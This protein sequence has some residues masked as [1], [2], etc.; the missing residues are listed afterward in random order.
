[1]RRDLEAGGKWVCTC[2]PCHEIRSLIG[3]EKMLDVWPLVRE[4]RETEDRL[5]ELADGP[6]RHKLQQRYVKLS[7]KLADM[8]AKPA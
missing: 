1:M 8:M 6:E 2:D 7:D 5:H 4:I 3:L